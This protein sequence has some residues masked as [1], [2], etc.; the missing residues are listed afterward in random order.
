MIE[1]ETV[2]VLGA[3]ASKGFAFPT[4][5]ELVRLILEMTGNK[6]FSLFSTFYEVCHG[7]DLPK[8]DEFHEVFQK[9]KPL[10]INA[11]LE[12]NPEFIEI[13][14]IAIAIA[15]L[16]CER[17]GSL[18][19]AKKDWYQ[20]L[21]DRINCPI[22]DFQYNKLSIVTFN[23]DRSLE[24]HL[25]NSFRY[26]HAEKSEE[27]CK[28]KLNKLHIIHV[29]GSLGRLEWQFDNPNIPLTH[30]PYGAKLDDVS[31]SAAA[32]NIK[33][34]SE[35]SEELPIEFQ[36]ARRLIA[37][38]RALYFLGFGYHKTNMDR[39]GIDASVNPT[40]VMGTAYGLDYQRRREVERLRITELNRH[41]GLVHKP[42]YEFIHDYIDFN[43]QD[44]PDVVIT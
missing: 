18:R 1:L 21:F 29:Y 44:L 19:T 40:K 27:E 24:Q 42:V 43:E 34:M 23:Y 38:A 7:K 31:V 36:E 16:E 2:L 33:I 9:A 28:K 20:L 30:V 26:T 14:K 35:D 8:A 22:E 12:H 25:F 10:S 3:G 4:G 39:L 37:N 6:N 17:G 15:L 5:S 32:D 13:G 41:R 11:W